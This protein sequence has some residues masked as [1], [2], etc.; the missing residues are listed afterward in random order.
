MNRLL[1]CI[2]LALPT[3]LLAQQPYM[4]G[5]KF[6][7][8]AYESVPLKSKL[9]SKDRNELPT[10]ADLTSYV[11]SVGTQVGGTCTGFATAYY[12]R[13]ILENKQ[14]NITATAEK[15]RAI[16]SPSFIYNAIKDPQD[17]QC[18]E[19]SQ[20]E[21]AL[22][23][24]KENGVP[25]LTEVPYPSCITNADRRLDPASKIAGYS[26]LFSIEDPVEVKIDA[27]KKALSE[28]NPVVIA[29][30]TVESLKRP[31]TRTGLWTPAR[32]EQPGDG[33]AMC[34]VGYDDAKYGG[35][36][37]IV[38]SWGTGYGDKGYVW[39]KYDDYA[40]YVRYGFEA[41]ALP[42]SNPP[43]SEVTLSASLEFQLTTGETV[44]VRQ[45]V[46][47]KGS[48]IGDDG[49]GGVEK[50]VTYALRDPQTS[51][52]KYKFFANVGK[53]S[54][55]YVIGTDLSNKMTTLFPY[56]ASLS[57]IIG[58]NTRVMLP[59]ETKHFFLDQNRGTDFWLFLF[60]DK[61]LPIETLNQR[62]AQ[63]QGT[64]SDRIMT[65]FGADLVDYR[66]ISYRTDQVG[67]ERKGNPKGSI[68]P[69]LVSLQHN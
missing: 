38:N 36:F 10:R 14:R 69:V 27:T 33:H 53:Q 67:F 29:V 32:T 57:P 52:T 61:E 8:E 47:S 65:V 23:Y 60:S 25:R 6:N 16:F 3:A 54:Y 20:I 5:L 63:S 55:L 62:L 9:V 43:V 45:S 46:V 2:L 59:S 18:Q 7:D 42:K 12:M 4:T 41:F 19:G 40:Y 64:F 50:M 34:V 49:G 13:T 30:R 21:N 28:G 51:G 31:D 15:D 56:N 22:R 58:A 17:Q 1:F 68:V 35:A 26:R 24:L 37:R 11:P 66:K 44:P 48:G 39:A